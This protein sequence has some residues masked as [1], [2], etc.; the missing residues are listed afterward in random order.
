MLDDPYFI[1]CV[2]AACVGESA[3]GGKAGFVGFKP[4]LD[5]GWCRHG[6]ECTENRMQR[7]HNAGAMSM[8]LPQ[9][10]EVLAAWRDK[11]RATAVLNFQILQ[12][13]NADMTQKHIAL[14]YTGG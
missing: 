8:K 5:N 14:I 2:R 9:N 1:R 10:D 3:H 7:L 11:P 4:A 6:C 13:N 12:G